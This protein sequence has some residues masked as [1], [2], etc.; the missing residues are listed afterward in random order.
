MAQSPGPNYSAD[1]PWARTDA[2]L[3]I[4]AQNLLKTHRQYLE[5]TG[6]SSTAATAH[7]IQPG[8]VSSAPGDE[9]APSNG[10]R[11][12]ARRSGL[13]PGHFE[14]PAAEV[15]QPPLK[16]GNESR[17]RKASLLSP[18]FEDYGSTIGLSHKNGAVTAT[19]GPQGS[20]PLTDHMPSMDHLEDLGFPDLDYAEEQIPES[21]FEAAVPIDPNLGYRG[22]DQASQ[23][24]QSDGHASASGPSE[25][26]DPSLM[27]LDRH[28]PV[29]QAYYGQG[30][31]GGQ[32]A[33]GRVYYNTNPSP[34][35]RMAVT[36]GMQKRQT[37]SPF[38]AQ[39]GNAKRG[40][41][42][43]IRPLPGT[44]S[45]IEFPTL[46]AD[47]F[48][49]IQEELADDAFALLIAVTFLIKTKGTA[50]IPTFRK[51]MHRFPSQQDLADAANTP[52]LTN[53][54]RHLGLADRRVK[55]IQRI[56]RDWLARPPTRSARYQVRNY[57]PR[58]LSLDELGPRLQQQ[59][60]TSTLSPIATPTN[61]SS[62]DM[63]SW[64]IG[65]LTQG[66]YAIDSW[67]IFCRD[68]LLGKAR[69]WK[70]AG[71]S[72]H[73]QPEWMRVR[74]QDKEL[75]AFLRWMWIK[76]G[77]EWDPKTGEKIPTRPE[78]WEAVNEKRVGWDPEGNLVISEKV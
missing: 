11:A 78:M 23:S 52:L 77:W 10:R 21:E 64:E 70:G 66:R 32:A 65:H 49:I 68:V 73:F 7:P 9:S 71:A 40:Q 35:M 63:D 31:Q 62:R 51:V 44:V 16:A 6:V 56:A 37:T 34:G 29:S 58:E 60:T 12:T 69:D 43:L 46:E 30:G 24:Y 18:F 57:L 72:A 39:E 14:Q 22:F 45:C 25:V 13:G 38:F 5:L 28:A 2:L 55:A 47:R 76:E 42:Q 8:V 50:A 27:L 75:R 36:P 1:Q 61:N 3:D 26:I 59:N 20:T 67:R 48:G 17:S 74:P 4:L 54:I 15:A 19:P 53:M 41:L 33:D